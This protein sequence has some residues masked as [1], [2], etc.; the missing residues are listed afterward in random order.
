[1]LVTLRGFISVKLASRT[2]MRKLI[3]AAFLSLLVIATS[4]LTAHSQIER[5]RRSERR[6]NESVRAEEEKERKRNEELYGESLPTPRPAVK[7]V[8]VQGVLSTQE[9]K[10][11]AEALLRPATRVAG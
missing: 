6:M 2:F 4:S 8:D 1:M 5:I 9:A 7:N 11:F 10:S 3:S